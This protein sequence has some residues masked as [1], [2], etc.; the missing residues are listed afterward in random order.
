MWFLTGNQLPP[1]DTYTSLVFGLVCANCKLT[2][3]SLMP[4]VGVS[5][6]HMNRW[7]SH[8]ACGACVSS[9]RAVCTCHVVPCG[10]A[11]SQSQNLKSKSGWARPPGVRD[12][13][14][15]R[16]RLRP[17][18][19]IIPWVRISDYFHIPLDI[20]YTPEY[21]LRTFIC[22]SSCFGFTSSVWKPPLVINIC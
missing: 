2:L 5:L 18:I 3:T 6:G 4:H 9:L 14:S 16:C 20:N 11:K 21:V 10:K 13:V 15:V 19:R 17:C 22:Q 8:C 7:G 12:S 1:S